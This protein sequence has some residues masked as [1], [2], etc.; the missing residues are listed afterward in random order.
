M[1]MTTMIIQ[2]RFSVASMYASYVGPPKAM[3]NN[4]NTPATIAKPSVKTKM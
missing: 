2:D 1:V 3:A 4:K